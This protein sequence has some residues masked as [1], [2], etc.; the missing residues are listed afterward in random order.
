MRLFEDKKGHVRIIEAF[1][2][3]I[4][5]I[6]ALAFIP[7]DVPKDDSTK[8][9]VSTAQNVLLSLDSN[10]NLAS[11]IDDHNWTAVKQSLQSVLPLSTW[12]NLTVYDQNLTSLNE[13]SISNTGIVSD[14]IVSIDYVCASQKPDF[15]IYILRLQLSRVD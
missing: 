7:R 6:S 3:S 14:K 4:L 13:Y 9:L 2:A 15:T 12:F 8:A 5:L 11:L 1:F 10:G